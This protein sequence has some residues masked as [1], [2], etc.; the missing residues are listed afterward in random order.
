MLF[1]ARARSFRCAGAAP[2]LTTFDCRP[3]VDGSNESCS[4]TLTSSRRIHVSGLRSATLRQVFRVRSLRL[5]P[6]RSLAGRSW[7]FGA[8]GARRLTLV[9]CAP[10]YDVARGGYQPLA[11]VTAVPVGGPTRRHR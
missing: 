5:V 6:Q 11:V 3:F 4:V 9:T 1:W 10:P 2:T 8:G 7:I